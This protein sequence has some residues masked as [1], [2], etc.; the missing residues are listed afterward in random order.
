M[1]PLYQF[2]SYVYDDTYAPYYDKYRGHLFAID[3]FMLEDEQ[4]EH[5]WIKCHTD[6]TLEVDGYIHF[7]DLEE[8]KISEIDVELEIAKALD[9]EIWNEIES[10]TGKT[11]EQLDQEI[12]QF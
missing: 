12:Q 5:V 6:P 9:C 11:K 4:Q 3:H 7:Y 8:V 10:S 2:K 1:K